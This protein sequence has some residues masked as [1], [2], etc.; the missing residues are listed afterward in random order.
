MTILKLIIS[1]PIWF[2]LVVPVV[3]TKVLSKIMIDI[4]AIGLGI[5]LLVI[6]MFISIFG[7]G[8]LSLPE[9]RDIYNNWDK[10]FYWGV[11]YHFI[12]S[13]LLK[14]EI[15]YINSF[16]LTILSN[17]VII[18]IYILMGFLTYFVVNKESV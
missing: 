13:L 4:N 11:S 7:L 14:L 8:S 16:E 12:D 1:Y 15:T 17:L 3:L 6:I 2:I 5:L 9:K 10:G 18:G